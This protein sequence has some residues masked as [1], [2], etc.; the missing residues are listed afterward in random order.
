MDAWC[1]AL[2][3]G[4]KIAMLANPSNPVGCM[5]KAQEFERLLAAT[6]AHTLLVVDEA[7]FEYA[8]HADGY[9]DVLALLQG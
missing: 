4:P 3:R 9:P 1:E 6:P 2:R 7:D 5:F 8:C